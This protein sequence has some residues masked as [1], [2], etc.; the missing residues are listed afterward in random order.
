V[1]ISQDP[2]TI[3]FDRTQTR[4]P[5]KVV[6]LSFPAVTVD[7][8]AVM[9]CCQQIFSY[10]F[11]K[12]KKGPAEN[13]T[14]VHLPT[15]PGNENTDLNLQCP[16]LALGHFPRRQFSPKKANSIHLFSYYFLSVLFISV[17]F[18]LVHC[19]SVRFG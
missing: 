8:E 11:V 12:N 13:K 9:V 7:I 19:I 15:T 16:L 6:G 10:H 17:H 4:I 3:E 14:S 1:E 2:K 5:G 18:F